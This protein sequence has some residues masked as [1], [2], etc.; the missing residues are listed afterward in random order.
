MVALSTVECHLGLAVAPAAVAAPVLRYAQ[1]SPP[2]IRP[3]SAQV[4]TFSR[5][6]HVFDAPYAA[7]VLPGA[8]AI[9]QRAVLPP[10]A[11][12]VFPAPF[13][14]PVAPLLPRVAPIAP[15]FAPAAPVLP[16]AGGLFAR[17]VPAVAPAFAPPALAP[18]FGPALAPALAPVPL[19]G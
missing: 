9:V 15:A 6:L 11:T 16:Y 2:S 5:N 13:A 17:S 18:A 1:V 10:P 4:N 8:P 14:A 3:F 19:L 7:G 12:P